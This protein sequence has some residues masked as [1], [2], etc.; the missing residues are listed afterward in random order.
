MGT[1]GVFGT[2][3]NEF[4]QPDGH[5]NPQEQREGVYPNALTLGSTCLCQIF[6]IQPNIPIILNEKV[7]KPEKLVFA[8][9]YSVFLQPFL[10]V[11]PVTLPMPVSVVIV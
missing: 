4:I 6:V 5:I 7:Q 2:L 11:L 3:R 1:N 9:M 10:M 8:H